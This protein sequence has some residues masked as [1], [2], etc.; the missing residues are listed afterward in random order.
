[1]VLEINVIPIFLIRA[2]MLIYY[3]YQNSKGTNEYFI[4]YSTWA[5]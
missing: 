1:L 5:V 2:E 4:Q 3:A